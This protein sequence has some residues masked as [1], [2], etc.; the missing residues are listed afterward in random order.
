M[1]VVDDTNLEIDCFVH[2]RQT[3]VT[4]RAS[5]T[6]AGDEGDDACMY[7]VISA[8]GRYIAFE[9]TATNL[10]AGG[11]NDYRDV[12]VVANPLY[13]LADD[14]PAASSG[15]GCVPAAPRGPAALVL[16]LVTVVILA[17]C[18]VPRST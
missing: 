17:R 3:G 8:D 11:T 18:D 14:T 13:S 6:A 9:S 4:A 5:L 15:D 12:Y 16:C 1:R 2:H 7:P 10:I